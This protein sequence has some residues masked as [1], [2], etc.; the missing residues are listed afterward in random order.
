M[1]PGQ[2]GRIR[3][4]QFDSEDIVPRFGQRYESLLASQV[5]AAT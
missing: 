4:K 2:A 3:A 1:M 5:E